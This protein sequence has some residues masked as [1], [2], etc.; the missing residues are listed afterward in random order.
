MS[1][2]QKLSAT[3]NEKLLEEMISD[4]EEEY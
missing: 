1:V 3:T 4:I 2:Y